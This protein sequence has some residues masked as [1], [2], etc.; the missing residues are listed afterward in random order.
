MSESNNPH[1]TDSPIQRIDHAH[2]EH[3]SS[4]APE[5]HSS[6]RTNAGAERPSMDGPPRGMRR[7]ASD[8]TELIDAMAGR[9]SLF[10]F[11][12]QPHLD[13][14]AAA[15]QQ[16]LGDAASI[17]P[18]EGSVAADPAPNP[19]DDILI[20]S[21]RSTLGDSSGLDIASAFL[22]SSTDMAFEKA[23]EL[24]RRS[25]SESA[26]DSRYRTI[27]LSGSDHGRTG[28]C[29]TASGRPELHQGYGPMMAGFAHVPAEDID[30]LRRRI[31]DQTAA[32][33]LSP[34]DLHDAAKPLSENYLAA[35]RELCD[36]HDLLLL[37]DESRLC[38]ASAATPFVFR[39]IAHIPV[40][41]VIIA[42]GLFAGL[43]G[44]ILLTNDR[45]TPSPVADTSR[46]PLSAVV[47]L[48]TLAAIRHQD[49]F[50]AV[51]PTMNDFTVE[52]ARRIGDYEFVRDIHATGMTLGVVTD[53]QS[54][55]LVRAAA[56]H[57]LRIEAAGETSIRMQ[58]PLV[59]SD[60]D[61]RDFMERIGATMD[62]VRRDFA[63]LVVS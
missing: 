36:D 41:A 20:D 4:S 14:I 38:V 57:G 19:T 5:S 15:T 39:S 49:I 17:D 42:G 10:G 23:I 52:L 7:R 11:G 50:D 30:S 29:R 51:E 46:Y 35:V 3:V 44:A 27:A 48:E 16:Y 37:V 34:V 32:V 45:V 18:I 58:P 21:L 54:G 61:Q 6:G 63:D 25:A 22:A 31:D 47:A 33:L 26:S 13:A 62:V 56:R 24:V 9:A 53:V 8:G 43:P 55:E 60:D 40:D 1:D 59:V 2:D 28:V 12:F